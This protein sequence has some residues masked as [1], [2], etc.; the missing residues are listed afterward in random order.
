MTDLPE[1]R[2]SSPAAFHNRIPILEVLRAILPSRGMVLEIAS[3]SGEHVT[4][5]AKQLPALE[6][7]PSDPSPSARASIAAWTTTDRL[8]NVRSPIDLD[9]SVLPWPVSEVDA[10]LAINMV[11][12]S[13]WSATQGLM[14]EAGRLLPSGGVLYLC[15]P[16]IQTGVP[17]A[18]SNAAFD[19]GLRQRHV[20]WGLR[21]LSDVEDEAAR[22]GLVLKAVSSM[23][24]N[25]LSLIL[26]R[27]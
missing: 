11:H 3:G 23:P 18:P 2:L 7:Q 24:V 8:S 1:P 27:K 17:L 25:N 21:T 20:A 12:N 19:E 6:W 14:E 4:Y 16:F 26:R 10:I 15:G 9:A 13:P 5:F 22:A